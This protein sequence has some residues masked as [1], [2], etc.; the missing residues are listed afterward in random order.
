MAFYG[1][2]LFTQKDA[3]KILGLT[4][5]PKVSPEHAA[6][7]LN[8]SMSMC[9]V[10]ISLAEAAP[11]AEQAK[12]AEQLARTLGKAITLLGASRG[13]QINRDNYARLFDCGGPSLDHLVADLT[14]YGTDTLPD[15]L[16]Q[17]T[18]GLWILHSF[19][20]HAREGWRKKRRTHYKDRRT[21][22]LFMLAWAQTMLNLYPDL[23]DARPPRAPAGPRPRI[24][25]G[26]GVRQHLTANADALSN[27]ETLRQFI[28][29]VRGAEPHLLAG[30]ICRNADHLTWGRRLSKQARTTG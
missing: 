18:I 8:F 5:K 10:R 27:D 3:A 19:A 4:R 21:P 25:D 22:N 9:L 2:S 14:R 6:A 28:A 11:P 17:A 12:W 29:T 20:L 30:F 16:E 24:T 23:F 1:I 7:K 15:A 13:P 26:D